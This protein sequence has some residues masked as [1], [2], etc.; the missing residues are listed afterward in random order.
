ML[1][2]QLLILDTFILT[3]GH[4]S[5]NIYCKFSL[6]SLPLVF[7]LNSI[8][9]YLGT[10]N[11][12]SMAHQD[13]NTTCIQQDTIDY[14]FSWIFRTHIPSLSLTS[15]RRN[16]NKILLLCIYIYIFNKQT[17]YPNNIHVYECSHRHS[18]QSSL[19]NMSANENADICIIIPDA[20]HTHTY[21][22]RH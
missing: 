16:K 8:S 9:K 10:G 12:N 19:F 3:T 22:N 5:R 18:V 11:K 2:L 21:L 14:K 13:V 20:S 1:I 15:N 6:I 17:G 7:P 4:F